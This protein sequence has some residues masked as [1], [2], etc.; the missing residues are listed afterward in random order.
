MKANNCFFQCYFSSSLMF[1]S[2][3]FFFSRKITKIL[4]M[5]KWLL[6]RN[7]FLIKIYY[8]SRK[9]FTHK[10][11]RRSLVLIKYLFAKQFP[12]FKSVFEGFSYGS[13]GQVQQ[14]LLLII[15]HLQYSNVFSTWPQENWRATKRETTNENLRLFFLFSYFIFPHNLHKICIF[16][17][18]FIVFILEEK[19]L[20]VKAQQQHK[21][22]YRGETLTERLAR[23]TTEI[24]IHT[25]LNIFVL[26]ND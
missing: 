5:K 22:L 17:L 13:D 24:Q 1:F 11:N 14:T 19:T 18:V 4:L 9:L 8:S 2:L 3:K 12:Q 26:W 16:S 20:F 23:S 21:K 25:A 10:E 7:S 15:N 6:T